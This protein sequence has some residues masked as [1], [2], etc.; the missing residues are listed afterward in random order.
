[1]ISLTIVAIGTTLPELATSAPQR[2][3]AILI[4]LWATSSAAVFSTSRGCWAPPLLLSPGGLA[5]P[6]GGAPG[7]ADRDH[8][9]RG[10]SCRS[11]VIGAQLERWEGAF[12]L[13]YYVALLS[14]TSIS[15]GQ[16]QALEGYTRAMAGFVI[17]LTA[18]TLLALIAA[19]RRGA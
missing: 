4:S 18:V 15:R 19:R 14:L 7:Y 5:V 13:G 1:M 6:L 2:G 11:L 8:G 12:F 9:G 3:V 10:H 16:S 17:P